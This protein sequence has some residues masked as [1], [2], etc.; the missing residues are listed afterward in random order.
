MHIPNRWWIGLPILAGLSCLA[1]TELTPQVEAALQ[2]RVAAWL[3]AAPGGVANPRVSVVGRD[4]TIGGVTLSAD[5][6]RRI[7]AVLGTEAGVRRLN[8]ATEPPDGARTR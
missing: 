4:V 8:D 5:D 2:A 7:F 6:K 1:D 3:A